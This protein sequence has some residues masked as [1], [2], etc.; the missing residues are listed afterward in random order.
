MSL[1]AA[2]ASQASASSLIFIEEMIM[3]SSITFEI[4]IIYIHIALFLSNC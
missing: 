1:S 4:S 2:L 3:P